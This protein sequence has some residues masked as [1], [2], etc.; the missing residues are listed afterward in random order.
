MREDTS[1]A[2]DD[3]MARAQRFLEAHYADSALALDRVA[4]EAGISR[5][6]F[7]RVFSSL[8]GE[9]PGECLRRLRLEAALRLVADP[10]GP[11]LT[12]VAYD[13]G[14]SS[15]SLFSRMFRQRYQESPARIRRQGSLRSPA[16]PGQPVAPG[17]AAP[18]VAADPDRFRVELRRV[19]A[20]RLACVLTHGYQG[21]AIGLAYARLHARARRAGLIPPGAATRPVGI[22]WDDPGITPPRLCRYYAGLPV[23][24]GIALPPGLCEMRIPPGSC[25]TLRYRGPASGLDEAF[26]WL[27]R[28]WLT[29]SRRMLADFP[30]WSVYFRNPLRHGGTS[31]EAEI[32]VL[33]CD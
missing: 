13:C 17:P 5:F 16:R 30:A 21:L 25:A 6:H 33:L 10:A 8:L 3:A 31:F 15:Q 1:A 26:G 7:H 20:T 19:G 28:D 11:S 23:A 4:D 22:S 29:A 27:Y 14:F 12:R 32:H 24:D 2:W 18:V 9:T